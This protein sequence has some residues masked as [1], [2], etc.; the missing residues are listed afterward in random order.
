[1]TEAEYLERD[2]RGIAVGRFMIEC[3]SRAPHVFRKAFALHYALLGNR[4][5][6]DACATEL[7]ALVKVHPDHALIVIDA[8]EM[9]NSDGANYEKLIG[10]LHATRARCVARGAMDEIE[11]GMK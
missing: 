4:P 3:R 2:A 10:I 11:R 8:L 5:E 6:K 7:E 1:M 9:A